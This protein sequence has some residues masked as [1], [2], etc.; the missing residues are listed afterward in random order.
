MA[1][2]Q[3]SGSS[4]AQRPRAVRS[5]ACCGPAPERVAQTDGEAFRP[6]LHAHRPACAGVGH[7]R[8]AGHRAGNHPGLAADRFDEAVRLPVDADAVA[9]R[10]DV[11]Q[12][13]AQGLRINGDARCSSSGRR[14]APVGPGFGQGG[15]CSLNAPPGRPTTA[16]AGHRGRS[17][18]G[19]TG[20]APGSSCN[21]PGG[22]P[23][24]DRRRWPARSR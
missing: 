20:S 23:R 2:G 9:Q 7:R 1:A 14:V 19:S 13:G 16:S 22:K 17:S 6:R 10:V 12:V 21:S 11:G 8:P 4:G 15:Q 5:E 24:P 3:A 18:A